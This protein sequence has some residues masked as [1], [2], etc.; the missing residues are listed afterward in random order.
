MNPQERKAT[1]SLASIFALRMLGLFLILPVFS[2]YVKTHLPGTT[3]FL[4]GI[5]LGVYGLTQALLQI[6]FG[7]LSD[8]FGRKPIIAFGLVLFASGS[9]VA[10]LAHSIHGII[11]GRA[12]QGAGAIGSTTL[13]LVADLTSEENRTKAM[14]TVGMTI[15]L[16]FSLAFIAGPILNAWIGVPGIFWLTAIFSLLGI[17]VLFLQVPNPKKSVFHRDTEAMPSQILTTLKNPELLRLNLGIFSLHASLTALFLVVP[18]TLQHIANIHA[19]DQWIIYLPVLILAFFT[20]LPFIIIAEKKRKIKPIF[21]S[22]ILVLLFAQAGLLSLQTSALGTAL[23]LFVYFTGFTLLEALLPSLISKIAPSTHK[24]TA[25]GIYSSSQFL[26]IFIGG[27]CGGFLYSH[28]QQ[29]GVFAFGSLLCLLWWLF[30][31]SMQKPPHYG[32]HLINVGPINPAQAQELTRAF[33]A[34]PG[35]AEAVVLVEDGIAYLKVDNQI[36]DKNALHRFAV[37]EHNV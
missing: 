18:V 33:L 7:A 21:T 13:A 28:F 34:L 19:H 1:F 8:R 3:L 20:M 35:V 4:V 12:L 27:V 14:A 5:A 10:A 26:G 17:L 6:P 30:A 11:I 24:G 16:A 36:V 29:N 32:T 37:N 22:A 15:G 9:I 25:M 23:C 2:I 31:I